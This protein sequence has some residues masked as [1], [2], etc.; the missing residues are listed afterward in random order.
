MATR[1]ARRKAILDAAE[2][3]LLAHGPRAAS[4][5]AIAVRAG[6][7]KPTLYAY[8]ADKPALIAALRERFAA[9]A[10]AAVA[11]GLAGGEA[12]PRRLGAA[13]AGAHK[14]MWRRRARSPHAD[15]LFAVP[16]ESAATE[17]AAAVTAEL[18]DAGIARP[19]PLAR[20]LLAATAGIAAEAATAAELGP[21]I[22]LLA[23]RLLAPDL[24]PEGH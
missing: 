8:F 19:R 14:A 13:L 6:I 3:L 18:V 24:P 11:A 20:L 12:L 21:A 15:A 22:R 2:A 7:A 16:A 10:R 9:D 17:I 4:M 5:A 1:E 23:E